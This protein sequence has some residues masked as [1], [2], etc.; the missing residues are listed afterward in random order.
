MASASEAAVGVQ[1]NIDALQQRLYGARAR[2]TDSLAAMRAGK[3]DETLAAARM[4]AATADAADLESMI[5]EVRPSL[6]IAERAQ[7]K[8]AQD[9]QAAE[10]AV[11]LE[12][13]RLT[14]VVL[15][16]QVKHIEG[17]LCEALAARY[18]VFIEMSGSRGGSLFRVWQPTEALRR[19][20]I[21]MLP[22]S[23]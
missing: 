17:K 21:D 5:T 16:D 11:A 13:L 3:L 6:E 1:A 20:V 23:A 7:Q 8:A 18:Q 14:A 19:A 9:V 15:D 10:R 12:E 22:P 2:Y 4:A